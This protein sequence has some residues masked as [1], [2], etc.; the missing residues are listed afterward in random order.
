M[1]DLG[2]RPVDL[3]QRARLLYYWRD[4]NPYIPGGQ[5][6][7]TQ[8]W[9]WHQPNENVEGRWLEVVSRNET[10]LI[11]LHAVADFGGIAFTY[12]QASYSQAALPEYSSAGD[13]LFREG[14]YADRTL[15]DL[16]VDDDNWIV[17]RSTGYYELIGEQWLPRHIEPIGMPY[18]TKTLPTA[19]ADFSLFEEMSNA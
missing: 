5:V 16:W 1:Q 2:N 13:T 11:P 3:T 17:S 10:R 9:W 4:S 7:I 6:I 19:T 15:D 12:A 18:Q 14:I 8:T